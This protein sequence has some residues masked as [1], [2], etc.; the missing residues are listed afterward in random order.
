[1][2][3]SVILH[4][5]RLK[6]TV[7]PGRADRVFTVDETTST[8]Y[9]ISS[10]RGAAD[11]LDGIDE[12]SIMCHGYCNQAETVCGY[13][14]QL[15]KDD[16][17]LGNVQQWSALYRLIGKIG[18]FACGAADTEPGNEGTDWDGRQLCSLLASYTNAWVI[19]STKVQSF[20]TSM[21]VWYWDWDEIDFGAWEGEVLLFG[22]SGAVVGRRDFSTS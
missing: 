4:D 7:S 8:D 5:T 14:I 17:N 11:Q 6:G 22:P 18:V 20:T 9:I 12:L 21:S 19:A 16:L 1:M 3:G 15:G 2:A 10:L 13:G